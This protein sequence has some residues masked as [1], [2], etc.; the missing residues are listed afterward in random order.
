M[1][2]ALPRMP[3]SNC[4]PDLA[5]QDFIVLRL[6]TARYHSSNS[7]LLA[8]HLRQVSCAKFGSSCRCLRMLGGLSVFSSGTSG[9]PVPDRHQ[10]CR[11]LPL[12]HQHAR[13]GAQ[14]SCAM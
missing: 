12:G 8:K 11:P 2:N 14:V 9:K 13:A 10:S 7:P 1:S 5:H 4:I 6:I 3:G